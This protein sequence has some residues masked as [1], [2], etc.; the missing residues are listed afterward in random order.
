MIVLP[1]NHWIINLT[2]YGYHIHI[3]TWY[4]HAFPTLA[5][6]YYRLRVWR[7]FWLC[8]SKLDEDVTY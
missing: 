2:L 5:K 7:L 3:G 4:F 1:R 8:F 6:H